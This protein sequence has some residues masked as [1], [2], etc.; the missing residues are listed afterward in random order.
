MLVE[1]VKKDQQKTHR[2][3]EKMRLKCLKYT[4]NNFQGK[5]S[6]DMIP[7]KIDTFLSQKAKCFDFTAR[8]TALQ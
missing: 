4:R 6:S 5:T 2:E 7:A 8:K 3:S 1:N